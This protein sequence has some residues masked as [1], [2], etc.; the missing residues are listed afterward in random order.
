MNGRIK[1][2][3]YAASTLN[4]VLWDKKVTKGKKS[5]FTIQ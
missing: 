4:S 5:V 1:L 2:G 3:R